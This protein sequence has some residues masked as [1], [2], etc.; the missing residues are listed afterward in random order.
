[1]IFRIAKLPIQGFK[2]FFTK[3]KPQNLAQNNKKQFIDGSKQ[4]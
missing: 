2:T 3:G 1:L 4:K